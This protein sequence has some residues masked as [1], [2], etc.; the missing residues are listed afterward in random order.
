MIYYVLLRYNKSWEMKAM[1]IDGQ[2]RW[3]G[4]C[5]RAGEQRCGMKKSLVLQGCR[6]APCIRVG[7]CSP[8]TKRKMWLSL[9]MTL[10]KFNQGHSMEEKGLPGSN[11]SVPH[12]P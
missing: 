2:Q 5:V 9:A 10:K 8:R 6:S 11:Q 12:P 7:S 1:G 4:A 3:G